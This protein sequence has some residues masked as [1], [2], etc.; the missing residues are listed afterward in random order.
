[1][2]SL[3]HRGRIALAALAL[4][5]TAG[6]S[7]GATEGTAEPEI[8]LIKPGKLVV[9]T[10]MP[11][12]P[13]A[14]VVD[15]DPVGFDVDLA[16]EV[17]EALDVSPMFLDVGFDSITS[18]KALNNGRCDL[19]VSAMTIRSDR[20]RVLDFSSPYF[21][22]SQV[23]VARSGTGISDLASTAGKRVGA[24]QDTTGEVYLTDH[25]PDTTKIKPFADVGELEEALKQG[26]IDAA[27]L[28]N[29]VVND[30]VERFP[31]VEIAAEFDTGEQYGMAVAKNGNIDL[32]RRVNEVIA[33]IQ[34][35]GRY[36]EIYADWFGAAPLS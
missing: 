18:G 33:D 12:E 14:A 21:N 6:C 4:L 29:T 23:M 10:D 27:V 36:G 1:M 28:D 17:A 22:A 24:Q 7:A 3:P 2:T 9:C 13:F 30:V 32:L 31:V 5:A 11:Y 16:T 15:G 25:A 8:E 34:S 26:T 19:A 35:N 20:A